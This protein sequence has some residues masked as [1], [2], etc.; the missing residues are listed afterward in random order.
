MKEK[1]EKYNL[2]KLELICLILSLTYIIIF[3][4]D[5]NS[6]IKLWIIPITFLL[7]SSIYIIKN[8]K[9][10]INNR[11]YILL[12][13]IVLMLLSPIIVTLVHSNI[14]I[15][16]VLPIVISM[17]FFILTNPNYKISLK[18]LL[19]IFK[20]IPTGFIDNFI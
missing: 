20:I 7:V 10:E 8:N 16:I 18:S 2:F 1:I 11:A 6:W 13:P 5:I 19:W 3:N 15:F 14:T 9:L 4:L 17:F 12:I